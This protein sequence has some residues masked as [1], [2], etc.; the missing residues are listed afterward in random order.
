MTE[1]NFKKAVETDQQSVP[2]LVQPKNFLQE[3]PKS[4]TWAEYAAEIK[5]QRESY[6]QAIFSVAIE[7]SLKEAIQSAA[8]KRGRMKGGAKSIIRDGMMA[9]FKKHPEM[10]S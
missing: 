9:Y 10:F 6:D 8:K 5:K 4:K 7:P 1:Q 2:G 3:E